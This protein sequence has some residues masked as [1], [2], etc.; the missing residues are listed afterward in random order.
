MDAIQ[1]IKDNLDVESVLKHYNFEDISQSGNYLRACCKLH[2]GSNPTA[3]VI[4][5]DEGLWSCHTGD[6]G[7][8]DIFHLVQRFER[9]TFPYAVH[10]VAEILGLDLTDMEIVARTRKERKEVND[11]LK[12]LKEHNKQE[13]DVYK[14]PESYKKVKKYKEFK[15]ETMEYFDLRYYDEFDCE[16]FK[17]EKVLV[18]PI[19]QKGK[20]VGVS[21]RA[22][23]PGR[24]KWVHQPNNM[25]TGDLLYNYDNAM[26]NDV[27]VVV[28]GITDVWAYHEIGVKAVATY[29]AHIKKEQKRMLLRTGADL[30]FSFDGDEAGRKTMEQAKKEFQ[31]TSNIWFVDIPE[32]KDPESISR[33]ELMELYVK[34]RR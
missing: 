12:T 10:K 24:L 7:N 8:G 11:F 15:K 26:G 18:F 27:I 32:G 34:R 21:L 9:T 6:C 1:L 30:V 25:K 14:L 23:L 31:Y 17:M 28:E 5:Y 16:T 4:H 33:E 13:Q 19:E 22:T 20:I 2:D 3:F 29:G